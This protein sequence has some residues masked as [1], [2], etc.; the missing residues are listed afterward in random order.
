MRSKECVAMILAGGQGSRLGVLT[1]TV[2]KPAVPFGG[3]YR[4]IDFTLSNCQN[5]G[6]DTV[7]VLTQ[8]QPLELHTYIGI[9]SPWD[10][11]RNN[12]GVYILPPFVQAKG[13]EWYKGTANAIYQNAAFIDQYN[14]EYVLVLSGDHIYKMD[15]SLMLQEHKKT[16]ADATIAV[17]EVPWKEASRFGIMNTDSGGRIFEF[18]EKPKEPK[19]NLASMGVYIFTWEVLKAYLEK[20]NNDAIS[21]HDFGKNVIPAMLKGGEKLMAYS[22]KGY[23]K[24]VGTI[25]SL[26]EANMDLLSDEPELNLYDPDWRIFSVNPTSPPHLVAPSGKVRRSLISVGCLIFGEVENSVLFAGVNIGPGAVVKDSVIMPGAHIGAGAYLEKTI[27][28]PQA[29]IEDGCQIGCDR[30]PAGEDGDIVVVG[31]QVVVPAETV[32]SSGARVDRLNVSLHAVKGGK[33]G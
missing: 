22:F 31:E 28:G 19:N 4:L 3:K 1:N 5:S 26:W 12:G 18:D 17:I 21:D 8:Y 32:V 13:G 27:V 30:G 25:G 20:D 7:G 14:P 2:A 16:Q 23:W 29:V 9:G 10:L 15:Y 33:A 11:D 24:D 6:F